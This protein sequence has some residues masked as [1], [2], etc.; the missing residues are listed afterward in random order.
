MGYI[1]NH[2]MEI[3]LC[4]KLSVNY[5]TLFLATLSYILVIIKCYGSVPCWLCLFAI[6]NF[7][8]K[9][10]KYYFLK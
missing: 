6:L 9:V 8:A 7:F 3:K 10:L 5:I 2:V 4:K 1:A